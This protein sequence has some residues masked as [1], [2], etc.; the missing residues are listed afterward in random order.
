LFFKQ[1]KQLK[2]K[3][4]AFAA[5]AEVLSA[6]EGLAVSALTFRGIHFVRAHVDGVQGAVILG[7]VV[8]FALLNGTFDGFIDLAHFDLPPLYVLYEN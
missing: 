6:L 3:R 2:E 4:A 5:D 1:K 7:S 8:E